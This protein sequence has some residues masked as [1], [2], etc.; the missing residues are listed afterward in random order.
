MAKPQQAKPTGRPSSYTQEMGAIICAG[1][2]DGRSLRSICSDEGLPDKS[3]VFRWLEVNE[4]FRDQYI[5]AREIQADT[6]FDVL[7]DISDE[8]A[9]D[10]AAV[11]RNKLRIETRKWVIGKLKP[12]I[13]GDKSH[14]TVEDDKAPTPVTVVVEVKDARKN[15][16]PES[17]AVPIPQSPA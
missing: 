15:A 2:A 5:R 8:K 11:S 16:E 1:I 17:T 10:A 3:T 12:K 7:M 4:S 14:E 6:M 9:E 13:Y